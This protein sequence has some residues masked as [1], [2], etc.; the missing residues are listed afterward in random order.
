MAE[1]RCAGCGARYQVRGSDGEFARE[2]CRCERP[3]ACGVCDAAAVQARL[4]DPADPATVARYCC[5]KHALREVLP[6]E[7]LAPPPA[8][9]VTVEPADDPQCQFLV[10]C[11]PC[12]NVHVNAD[13][14]YHPVED[15]RGPRLE[16]RCPNCQATGP[17][18]YLDDPV[19]GRKKRTR[20]RPQAADQGH[21]QPR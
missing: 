21:Y 4:D 11:A 1:S 5:P 3:R 2:L 12:K 9:T 13:R 8:A 14:V 19:P 17:M 6:E 16:S 18:R 10:E 15:A 7:L 20:G